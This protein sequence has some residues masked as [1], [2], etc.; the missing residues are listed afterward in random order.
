[1]KK[2][3]LTLVALALFSGCATNGQFDA[4]KTALVVGSIILVGVLASEASDDG[5]ANQV[6]P[7][8]FTNADGF[9]FCN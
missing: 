1:M 4:G 2:T 7:H 3:I 9:T 5:S 8:C 6:R